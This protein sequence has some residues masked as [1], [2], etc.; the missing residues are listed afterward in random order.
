MLICVS[1][2]QDMR[3]ELQLLKTTW[4]MVDLVSNLFSS[5]RMTLWADINTDALLEE[6]KLLQ[7]ST[8]TDVVS[9]LSIV[10]QSTRNINMDCSR[11]G[12]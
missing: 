1:C 3:T 9:P 8:C 2:V 6:T 5:W 11:P 4:D 10:H 12:A 7:A